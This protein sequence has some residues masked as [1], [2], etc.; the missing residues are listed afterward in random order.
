MS[1]RQEYREALLEIP[2]GPSRFACLSDRSGL[3]GPRGN[4]ELGEAFADLAAPDEI[5]EAIATDDEYLVFC[6]VAGLGRL[7]A[8]SGAV[9]D[10]PATGRRAPASIERRLHSALPCRR[11]APA[12]AR[13]GGDG[14]PAPGRR[15]PGPAVRPGGHLVPGHGPSGA[16]SGRRRGVRPQAAA[17]TPLRR[18]G[19][20]GLRDRDTAEQ[21]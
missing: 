11:R 4:I 12:G 19:G 7:L 15:G 9:P 13:G 21:V 2:P 17:A 3:P 20:G 5:D 16:A 18:S 14:A 8:E 6:G 10:A 1:R